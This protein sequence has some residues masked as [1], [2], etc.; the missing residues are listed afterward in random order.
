MESFNCPAYCT[1]RA[2]RP[3]SEG[4]EGN[5]VEPR[6]LHE[7]KGEAESAGRPRRLEIPGQSAGEVKAAQRL[8]NS[9]HLRRV[10]LEYS[11]EYRT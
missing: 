10:T 8:R 11:S 6:G 7:L 5:H 4:V 9:R 2:R 1:E 3:L